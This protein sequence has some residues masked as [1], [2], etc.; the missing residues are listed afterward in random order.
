LGVI[1]RQASGRTPVQ[2]CDMVLMASVA[3]VKGALALL[4]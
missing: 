2:N 4:P 1:Q 3:S